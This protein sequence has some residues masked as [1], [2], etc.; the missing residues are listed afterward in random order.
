MLTSMRTAGTARPVMK[1]SWE[2][3]SD[4]LVLWAADWV[5]GAITWWLDGNEQFFRALKHRITIIATI[6]IPVSEC[7]PASVRIGTAE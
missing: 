6:G 7:A 2:Q 1:V 4:H 5:A 3:P